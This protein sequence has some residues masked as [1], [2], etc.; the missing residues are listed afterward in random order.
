MNRP[1][2]RWMNLTN[3]RIIPVDRLVDLMNLRVGVMNRLV[4]RRGTLMSPLLKNE[5][6]T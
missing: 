2:N 4:N 5:W 1:G 6:T 3:R